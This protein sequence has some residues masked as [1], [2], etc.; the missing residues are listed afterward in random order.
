MVGATQHVLDRPY[1][2]LALLA[3][4]PVL[5]GQLPALQ[6]IVLAGLKAAELLL[7]GEVHPELDQHHAL[8]AQSA[9]EF[10][11]LVVRALHSRLSRKPFDPLDQHPAVPGSIEHGHPAPA[12]ERGR[13]SPQEVVALLPLTRRGEL[14][15]VTCRASSG[16]VRRRIAPPFPDA[17]QPSKT[18]ASGGPSRPLPAV[19]GL[20]A[21]R[22]HSPLS[23]L[24]SLACLLAGELE[25][26][27]HR[28]S[29]P[30]SGYSHSRSYAPA[31]TRASPPRS[32]P[33][34]PAGSAARWPTR[35]REDGMDV[36][37][38]DLRPDP[39]GPGRPHEADLSTPAGNESA[40]AAALEHFGRLDVVVANAGIQ[41]VAP[42]EDFPV[43]R[44]EAIIAL[45]LTSPFLLAQHAWPA[46]RRAGAGRFIV[47]AS[48]HALA[49]SP[50]KVGIRV[51]QARRARAGQDAG[52]R[53]RRGRDHRH[54][55][56][57]RVRPHP[58]GREADRR[59][60]QGARAAP[61][62]G[63]SSR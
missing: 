5:V 14:R 9:L 7:V 45:L 39:D 43:E 12:R 3:V 60:G 36:L 61:R 40:V 52:A 25:C 41:H 38:V 29:R 13:E 58:A 34:Q 17:S 1:V 62:S 28:I 35:L 57:P 8:R 23:P 32:S 51:G 30:T 42:I 63:C 2:R 53:G 24:Q 19:P 15:T 21:E 16:A 54:R 55:G 46:L 11:D 6:R 48:A 18:I 44:W 33:A 4:A 10:D 22:Q 47:I 20:E 31:M 59:S 56:V 27:I 26:Q 49:A 50:Y 37:A